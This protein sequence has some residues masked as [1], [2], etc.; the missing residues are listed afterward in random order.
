MGKIQAED[1]IKWK[2][3]GL[4]SEVDVMSKEII[5]TNE[6]GTKLRN[7]ILEELNKEDS[8][9]ESTKPHIIELDVTSIK[10]DTLSQDIE[11]KVIK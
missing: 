7:K 5:S 6:Q 9:F 10:F 1:V 11:K 2:V 3:K 4:I 8:S